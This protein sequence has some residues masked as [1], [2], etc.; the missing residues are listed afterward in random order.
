MRKR[1]SG[2]FQF[3]FSVREYSPEDKAVAIEI[4]KQGMLDRNYREKQPALYKRVE[5]FANS[6]IP[7]FDDVPAMVN[8]GNGGRLFVAKNE[9]GEILRA[10]G[11]IVSDEDLEKKRGELVRFAVSNKTRGK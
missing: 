7:D 2:M 4:F 6:T 5:F 1:S 11:I 3:Y 10:I 8:Y 9:K